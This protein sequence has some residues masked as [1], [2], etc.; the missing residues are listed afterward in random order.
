MFTVRALGL[1]PAR[2]ALVWALAALAVTAGMVGCRHIGTGGRASAGG[3]AEADVYALDVHDGT[4][5]WRAG[6]PGVSRVLDTPVI[7]KGTYSVNVFTGTDPCSPQR[8]VL[9]VDRATGS[10]VG[11]N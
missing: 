8:D 2:V 4:I 11:T 5:A 1:R 10:R 6:Q 3:F 9:R 7:A